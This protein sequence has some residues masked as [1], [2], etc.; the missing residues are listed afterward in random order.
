MSALEA[1]VY[2]IP[3]TTTP[4]AETLPGFTPTSERTAPIVVAPEVPIG[5]VPVNAESEVESASKD[6]VLTKEEAP[7][8]HTPAVP[9]AGADLAIPAL[10]PVPEIPDSKAPAPAL[11]QSKETPATNSNAAAS[12]NGA[13]VEQTP[14]TSVPSIPTN[15]K[16]STLS[17]PTKK[18]AVP[19]VSSSGSSP[20][21]S[22]FTETST[23]PRKKRLS[24]FGKVKRLFESDRE[25]GEDKK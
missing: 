5:T 12:T 9:A 23:E 8:T 25:K 18:Q 17:T 6:A 19:F 16:P 10:S 4:N 1:H 15:V 24:F 20:T 14:T 11:P 21:S 7:T 22:R 13:A 3:I 2:Q